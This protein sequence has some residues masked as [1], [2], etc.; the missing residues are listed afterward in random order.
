[1]ENFNYHRPTKPADAVKAMKKAKDGKFLSGGMTLLP[2]MKQGLAAP[3]DIIDL[4]G[5]NNSGVEVAGAKVVVKAGTVHADV[6]ADKELKKAIPALA[7]LAGGIGDPHVRHRGTIG[8][9]IANND[10]AADY[11]AAVVGLN[12]T[13]VTSSRKIA[14]DKFFTDI[15]TTALKDDEIVTAVEFPVPKRAAYVKF[16]NPASLYAM[17]GVIVAELKDGSVRVAVTGAGPKVFRV[18]EM[19]KALEAKFSADAIAGIKVSPRGLNNDLHASPEYR[20]HLVNVL[21]RRAVAAAK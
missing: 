3:T 14:G 12:A 19:E 13:V 20:A 5:L 4:G 16:P 7:R 21:A 18:P 10:P 17:V 1:M 11:P 9:S 8:G 15:F 2:T 6:A